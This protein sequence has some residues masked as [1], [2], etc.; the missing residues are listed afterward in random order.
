MS[1]ESLKDSRSSPNM[2]NLQEIIDAAASAKQATIGYSQQ[3]QTP[4]AFARF[5]N[6]LLPH[7]PNS[8]AF[9][10]Q[11][12][13]GNTLKEGM[14]YWV[15]KFGFE[16]DNRYRDKGDGVNRLIGNC[17]KLWE[18]M[19][20]IFPDLKM[21]CQNANPPFGVQWAL[22]DGSKADSTEF[23]WRMI[24]QRAHE[25][26]YGWFISNW[27]TIERLGIDKH[28]SI[29]LYQKF[30]AG[31]WEKCEVEIGVVHWDNHPKRF[32][33]PVRLEYKTLELTEHGDVVAKVKKYYE[34]A[35]Q[36]SDSHYIEREAPESYHMGDAWLN[37]EE[38][39]KEERINRPPFNIWIDG[40]GILH[41]YLSTREQIKMEK[42]KHA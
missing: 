29:Y 25:H 41:T 21:E 39:L 24:M 34:R 10:P 37:I 27:K 38:I 28:P 14:P 7:F 26:G 15:K 5:F 11:C 9:D 42:A 2:E 4:V 6:G 13:G 31:V 35:Y 12:A 36:Y 20:D 40:K 19:D 22:P 16:I 32:N 23:T 1:D 18:I 33:P 30:P 17:V 3:Y 8:G